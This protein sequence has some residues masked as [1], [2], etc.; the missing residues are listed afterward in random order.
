M[1]SRGEAGNRQQDAEEEQHAGCVDLA[2]YADHRKRV[3]VFI[4]L[5]AMDVLGGDPQQAEAE[6]NAH[7]RRQMGDGLEDRNE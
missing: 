7:V 3:F 6:E 1:A 4:V 5:A 2:Q